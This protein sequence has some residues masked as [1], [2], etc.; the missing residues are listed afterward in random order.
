MK[1]VTALRLLGGAAA[2]AYLLGV[3]PWYL[4]WGATDFEVCRSM[5]GDDLVPKPGMQATRA[6]TID[7]PAERVWQWLVQIGQ[8]RGGFYSYD[9]LENLLGM[10]IHNVDRIVPELQHLSVGDVVP[11]WSGVGVRVAMIEPPRALV[12]GGTIYRPEGRPVADG[13]SENG[14]LGG[15]WAFLLEEMDE[16][17]TRLSVRTRAVLHPNPLAA[18]S[19]RLLLEPAHFVMERKMLLSLKQRAGG[20]GR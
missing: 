17:T 7:A 2:A 10:D 4:N 11:F 14:E 1:R 5:P 3:R 12:L 16:R 15:S 6:I 18:L 8:G 20:S 13:A 9:W 19:I